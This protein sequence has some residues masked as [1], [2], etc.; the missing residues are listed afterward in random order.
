MRV[1]R[2]IWR[3]YLMEEETCEDCGASFWDKDVQI[4]YDDEGRCLCTDCFFERESMK[5][6]EDYNDC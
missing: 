1:W 2:Q 5:E 6:M 3:D 4:V